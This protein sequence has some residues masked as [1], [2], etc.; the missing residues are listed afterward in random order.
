MCFLFLIS[1]ACYEEFC[2][3]KCSSCFV[4]DM[5]EVMQ[6]MSVPEGVSSVTALGAEA[7]AVK[8]GIGFRTPHLIGSYPCVR[9]NLTDHCF[10]IQRGRRVEL[11]SPFAGT[12]FSSADVMCLSLVPCASQ[13]ISSPLF[14]CDHTGHQNSVLRGIP[15]MLMGVDAIS[16]KYIVQDGVGYA[17]CPAK[18][19]PYMLKFLTNSACHVELRPLRDSFIPIFDMRI[20]FGVNRGP[21]VEVRI[22]VRVMGVLRI[23]PECPLSD[24]RN[25]SPESITTLP[26]PSRLSPGDCSSPDLRSRETLSDLLLSATKEYA[27]SIS[28]SMLTAKVLEAREL[29]RV[30][31]AS[32]KPSELTGLALVVEKEMKDRSIQCLGLDIDMSSVESN[33]LDVPLSLGFPD[34][35][36]VLG[37]DEGGITIE[38]L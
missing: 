4:A 16:V 25:V 33:L 35:D 31:W 21:P 11:I 38:P 20:T 32:I 26:G 9:K 36:L 37:D 22:P 17:V 27:G 6:E 34:S 13:N 28:L 12:G 24:P 14:Y 18:T 1:A 29:N 23:G 2:S 10:E 3:T 15:F 5:S 19:A 7:T 8:E 30:D